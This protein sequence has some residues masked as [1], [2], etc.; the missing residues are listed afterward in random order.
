MSTRVPNTSACTQQIEGHA[1]MTFDEK[2]F[3]FLTI[4]MLSVMIL[5]FWLLMNVAPS[6]QDAYQLSANVNN[7][8]T[9]G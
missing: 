3:R 2:L 7:T 6:R 9:H 1:I 5:I 8:T 4:V